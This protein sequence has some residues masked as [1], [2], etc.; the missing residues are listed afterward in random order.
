MEE[1]KN[2]NN[3]QSPATK[4][5]LAALAGEQVIQVI[6]E[7]A[8]VHKEVVETG[9]VH[10]RKTVSEEKVSINLPIINESYHIERIPI[11]GQVLDTP[12][13]AFRYEGDVMV[14]PVLKEITV[15]QKKYEVVEEVRI[16]RQ[17]TETPMVQEISLL[18]EH[19]HVEHSNK[20]NRE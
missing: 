15:V 12:P 6:H 10:I 7:H 18:K 11:T 5:E 20:G 19:I 9:K 4:T 16:T 2:R 13:A 1:M 14:I 8:T 17:L 3:E